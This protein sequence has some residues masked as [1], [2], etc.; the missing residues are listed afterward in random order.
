MIVFESGVYEFLHKT[1]L[2][3]FDALDR[4]M[5][6]EYEI[7][8]LLSGEADYV[9]EGAV[10]HLTPRTLLFIRPRRYHYMRR[11]EGAPPERFVIN[12]PERLVP[13]ALREGILNVPEQIRLEKEE[14]SHKLFTSWREGEGTQSEAERRVFL[15]NALPLLLLSLSHRKRESADATRV[16]HPTLEAILAYIEEHKQEPITAEMLSRRFF[17]SVS[18]IVHT[19]RQHLGV[20]LLQYVSRKRILYAES[21]IREG[22]APTEV[23]KECHY[24]SY[25]TFYRQYKK[26]LGKSP[27]EL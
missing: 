14:F 25:V 5:H 20:S 15:E 26:H 19:F 16:E 10:Y 4:H 12:F 7:L 22:I 1:G 9:I 24:D 17:V 21:R 6:N 27:S 2:P 3:T 18:W 11:G 23:A 8:Y 13:E